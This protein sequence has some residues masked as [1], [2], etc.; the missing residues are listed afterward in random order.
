MRRLLGDQSGI[1]LLEPGPRAWQPLGEGVQEHAIAGWDVME[2]PL[3]GPLRAFD[4][5]A[6]FLS[7]TATDSSIL[8][9][10]VPDRSPP[11]LECL[12]AVVASGLR[13]GVAVDRVQWV[14]PGSIWWTT[15]AGP[16]RL[17]LDLCTPPDHRRAALLLSAARESD[18][19][20]PI[21]CWLAAV[22]TGLAPPFEAEWADLL[23]AHYLLVGARRLAQVWHQ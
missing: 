9:P 22:S 20:D 14:T 5:A 12:R 15:R 16:T 23:A 4:A 8:A 17:P 7:A 11:P 19:L 10:A 13:A 1:R 3:D 18:P 6:R 21:S 2:V